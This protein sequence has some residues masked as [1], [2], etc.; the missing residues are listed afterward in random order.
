[1]SSHI[2]G[3]I[4]DAC[5]DLLL[6]TDGRIGLHDSIEGTI[7]R[8]VMLIGPAGEETMLSGLPAEKIVE[9]RRAQR[10]ITVLLDGPAPQLPDGWTIAAPT[11]EEVVV[12]R[13]REATRKDAA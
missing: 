11:L 3:E 6:L 8:H 7:A 13:F 1:M 4:Q 10:Q 2:L 9:I 5:D 12:A